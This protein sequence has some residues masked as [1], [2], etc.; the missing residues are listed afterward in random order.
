MLTRVRQRVAGARPHHAPTLCSASRTASRRCAAGA[1]AADPTLLAQQAPRREELREKVDANP[2]LKA[3]TRGAWDEIAQGARD[4][5]RT[6]PAAT[7]SR[8]R[9]RAS[10]RELF[11]LRP[12][13]WCARRTSAQAQRGAPARV[14]RRASCPPLTQQ[15]CCA[16]RRSTDELEIATLTFGCTKLRETLGADD[17]FVQA[18]A[19]QGVARRTSRRALVKGTK[20]GDVAVRKALLEGGKAAVDASNDPMILLARSVD[21]DGA[22]AAQALRG[23]GGGGA[24][25]RTASCSPRRAS[26]STAR[27]AT[28][29]PPS[30]CASTTAQ[31]K[32]W[33]RERQAGA[34]RSPRSAARSSAHTGKDAVRAAG[35]AG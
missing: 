6:M 35:D 25:A 15:L 11:A 27:A 29:T 10:A 17:P 21:A 34:R 1:G 33:E 14:H 28:R 8:S 26:R 20:L 31:V 30:R 18:G 23:H 5:R 22:R 13:R 24:Q 3:A 2:Q 16:R 9:A 12:A 7:G 19:R 32:G 4:V